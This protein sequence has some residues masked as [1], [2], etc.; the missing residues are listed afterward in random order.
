MLLEN[1]INIKLFV[2]NTYIAFLRINIQFIYNMRVLKTLGRSTLD[3]VNQ[4]S[5]S[6]LVISVEGYPR[7]IPVKF[8]QVWQRS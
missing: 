2:T 5:T 7:T 3:L 4:S 6:V 1:L 8:H